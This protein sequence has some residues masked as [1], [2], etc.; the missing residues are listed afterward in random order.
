MY[1]YLK[2]LN[3]FLNSY[4]QYRAVRV[5]GWH[6]LSPLPLVSKWSDGSHL[7]LI[8]Q[9]LTEYTPAAV[10]T[11]RHRRIGYIYMTRTLLVCVCVCVTSAQVVY[12]SV[13]LNLLLLRLFAKTY[14]HAPG[15]RNILPSN[16]VTNTSPTTEHSAERKK[17]DLFHLW[18]FFNF[19]M[20]K[21]DPHLCSY[22]QC[23]S[24]L[25]PCTH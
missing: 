20:V 13:T 9:W 5:L 21:G 14:W 17:G 19:L 12:C 11:H 6:Q 8:P 25:L 23:S 3:L 7:H 15:W 18:C 22:S 4:H 2:H 16:V 10:D 24:K 1:L